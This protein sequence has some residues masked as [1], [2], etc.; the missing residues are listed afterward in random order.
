MAQEAF[1]SFQPL[2]AS[3]LF[4]VH[5]DRNWS[6]SIKCIDVFYDRWSFEDLIYFIAAVAVKF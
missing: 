5:F 6:I 1:D 3:A 2:F 4:P